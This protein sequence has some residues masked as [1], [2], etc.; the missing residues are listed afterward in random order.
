MYK[1][2]KIVLFGVSFLILSCNVWETPLPKETRELQSAVISREDAQKAMSKELYDFYESSDKSFEFYEIKWQTY[3]LLNYNPSLKTLNVSEDICSGWIAQYVN[4]SEIDLKLLS[5][6]KL[7][8]N[9]YH[10]VL[11][12]EKDSFKWGI[13]KTNGCMGYPGKK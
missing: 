7:E 8:F 3:F 1:L 6:Q 11:N 13:I 5:E 10:Q 9:N 12:R 4:V 2:L